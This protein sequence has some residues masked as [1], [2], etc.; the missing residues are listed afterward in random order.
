MFD[1]IYSNLSFTHREKKW[2]TVGDT[3][4][5][6]YKWVPVTEPKSDDVCP[7]YHSHVLPS[8]TSYHSGN[9][10]TLMYIVLTFVDYY[11]LWMIVFRIRFIAK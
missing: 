2:V 1:V 9:P 11:R 6:I 5:R 10:P 8:V 4:L 7:Q 3:S